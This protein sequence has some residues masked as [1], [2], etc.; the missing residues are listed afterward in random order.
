MEWNSSGAA[1]CWITYTMEWNSSWAAH[2]WITYTM[3]WNSS[4]A[5]HCFKAN[6][7][8]PSVFCLEPEGS[9]LCSH[10]LPLGQILSLLKVVYVYPT[11]P[12]KSILILSSNNP[13]HV[14]CYTSVRFPHKNTLYISVL[15]RM[16]YMPTHL[17]DLDLIARLTF[18][19]EYRL[20]S[21]TL[22]SFF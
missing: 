11:I 8:I 2:C 7:E 13:R 4:W 3:E 5:A 10:S 19:E 22:C 15:L 6:Q 9:L 17:I 12:F 20:Q 18:S 16:C 14:K 21:S 1:H